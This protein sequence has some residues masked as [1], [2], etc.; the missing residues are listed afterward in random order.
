MEDDKQPHIVPT[1]TGA[2]RLEYETQNTYFEVVIYDDRAIVVSIRTVFGQQNESNRTIRMSTNK[3]HKNAEA[4]M[5]RDIRILIDQYF[6]RLTNKVTHYLCKAF[7]YTDEGDPNEYIKTYFRI[8][9]G[10][11]WGSGMS[12]E[13]HKAF[14]YENRLIFEDLGFKIL[15][16]NRNASDIAYRGHEYLYLHPMN[17]SGYILKDSISEITEAI[18]KATRYTL[19]QVDTYETI[20]FY[21]PEEFEDE[22]LDREP[23][24]RM[25]ILNSFK[26]KRK[27]LYV[28]E[29]IISNIKSGIS[30]DS[31]NADLKNIESDFIHDV[32][33]EM[34][35]SGDLEEKI[36][37]SGCTYYRSVK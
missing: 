37:E 34:I 32:F 35:A 21:N 15:P 26:T 14:V 31:A 5:L 8:D 18:S 29:Y 10:Y 22:L 23:E 19:R 17:F 11:Q 25:C 28:P 13:S 30:Y 24:I 12:Q 16:G 4:N 3:F 33:L 2:I 7:E 6:H 1:A 36:D 9:S 27:D 20:R